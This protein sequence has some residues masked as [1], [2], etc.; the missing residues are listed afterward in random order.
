MLSLFRVRSAALLHLWLQYSRLVRPGKL[1]PQWWHLCQAV[2][3][4]VRR[5]ASR[6]GRS[7]VRRQHAS[8]MTL[9]RLVVIASQPLRLKVR[10]LALALL[11][12]RAAATLQPPRTPCGPTPFDRGCRASARAR[13]QVLAGWPLAPVVC[14]SGCWTY[15]SSSRMAWTGG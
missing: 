13:S 3:L 5:D 10:A 12:I 9:L 1:V 11:A 6:A 15:S 7:P 4:V 8:L 14:C 2:G